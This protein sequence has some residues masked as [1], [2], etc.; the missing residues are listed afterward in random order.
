MAASGT[1]ARG[2]VGPS[3]AAPTPTSGGRKCIA[4]DSA[5]S[6]PTL[7]PQKLAT[8]SCGSGSATSPATPSVPP[9]SSPPHSA[10]EAANDL[11]D[12]LQ[13]AERHRATSRLVL[14][15]PCQPVC[16]DD[17]FRKLRL[18][19]TDVETHAQDR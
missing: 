5:T 15:T 16:L 17:V 6:A 1:R 14:W 11:R 10:R 9:S 3:S 8:R 12:L 2:M 4:T 7:S 13:P 18:G 19:P